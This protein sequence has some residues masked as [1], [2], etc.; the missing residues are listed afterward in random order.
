VMLEEVLELGEIQGNVIAGFNKPFMTFVYL[1][2]QDIT[3]ARLWMRDLAPEITTAAA[4]N[5]AKMA[6]RRLRA[7]RFATDTIIGPAV[8]NVAIGAPFLRALGFAP[9]ALK[10]TSFVNGLEMQ[11]PFLGDPVGASRGAPSGWIVGNSAKPLDLLLIVGSEDARMVADKVASLRADAEAR[12][13]RVI[14]MDEGKTRADQPGHEHF[15]FNDGISQPGIRGRK[16]ASPSDF[17]EERLIDPSDPINSIPGSPEFAAP[18]K[19]LVWPG[20][21]VFGYQT[22]DGA[23]QRSPGSPI[24]VPAWARNGSLLVFRRLYQDVQ[25]FR[26]FIARESAQTGITAALLGAKLVGRWASGASPVAYPEDDPG[27]RIGNDGQQNNSFQYAQAYGPIKLKDCVVVPK[28]NDDLFGQNCPFAAHLRK[29]NPRD[30]PTDE[31]S[32]AKTLTHRILRR[33]IPYGES[34]DL[35]DPSAD[36]G[37]LFVSYQTSIVNQFEFLATNWMNR[38]D[39][40]QSGGYDMIVGQN[41]SGRQRFADVADAAGNTQRVT[42]LVD[43]V[44]PT[45]GAYLFAPSI[46][47]LKSLA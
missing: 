45:G 47:F 6:F 36:R 4:G 31:Q 24:D 27:L 11:S 37:L 30:A 35:S 25:V 28:A 41:A 29:V 40:P 2:V 20:Q 46:S 18:G 1:R 8:V 34:F 26:D 43:F 5:D 13:F 17:F 22:Q 23:L 33:G 21:F 3:A 10:D 42:S 39:R 9:E 16:S 38:P 12:G 19:P 14:A 7:L 44:I 32:S 15:G